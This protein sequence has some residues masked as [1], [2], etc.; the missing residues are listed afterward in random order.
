MWLSIFIP[1][2]SF[3]TWW[4]DQRPLPATS[5][6]HPR[7]FPG[8]RSVPLGSGGSPGRASWGSAAVGGLTKPLRDSWPWGPGIKLP[9][10]A[11]PPGRLP[12]KPQL[13]NSLPFPDLPASACSSTAHPASQV[14]PLDTGPPPRPD[15][16]LEPSPSPATLILPAVVAPT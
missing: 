16:C 3:P 7:L 10:T 2:G 11:Q 1:P 13:S 15:L 12:L 4:M 6:H 9:P 14:L 8:L 5:S